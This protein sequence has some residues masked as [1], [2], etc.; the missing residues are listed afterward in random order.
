MSIV[1]DS[2]TRDLVAASSESTRL[3]GYRFFKEEI[4]L[5]G[6]KATDVRMISKFYLKKILCFAYLSVMI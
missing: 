4:V 1:I 5:H 3:S 6:V 2:L